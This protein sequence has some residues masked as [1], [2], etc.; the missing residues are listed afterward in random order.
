MSFSTSRVLR[1]LRRHL[2]DH[3]VLLRIVR[4]VDGRGQCLGEGVAQGAVDDA[5][6]QSQARGGVAV[7]DQIGLQAA[8]L[9]I[10]VHIGHFR[11]VLQG[12]LQLLRPVA[13]LAQ[14]I[15]QQRVLVFGVG[16]AAAAAAAQILHGLQ[17]H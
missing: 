11:H 7:H 13:Q 17:E 8:G 1:V 2:H 16:R 14:V 10:G 9:Q 15:P 5:F 3:V 6:V 12:D 4:V